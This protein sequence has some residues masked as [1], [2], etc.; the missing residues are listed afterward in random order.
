MPTQQAALAGWK[1]VRLDSDLQPYRRMNA[2][3][4]IDFVT[5]SLGKVVFISEPDKA[6][7]EVGG[8]AV[9]KTEVI[10]WYP[11]GTIK[12]LFKKEGLAVEKICEVSA[13]GRNECRAELK[14][15]S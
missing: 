2:D 12:V 7:V 11:K 3:S 4:F 6:D 9:G 5:T 10:R 8:R 1:F 13:P 15:S 14:P